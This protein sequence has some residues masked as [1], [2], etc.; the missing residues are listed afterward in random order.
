MFN[1]SD[2]K[3]LIQEK[4]RQKQKYLQAYYSQGES[5]HVNRYIDTSEAFKTV[6]QKCL[7]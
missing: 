6:T 7:H 1:F 3:I 4:S 5:E 2:S